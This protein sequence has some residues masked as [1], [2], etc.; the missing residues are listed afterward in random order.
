MTKTTE[1]PENW[2]KALEEKID[3]MR[4][5][6]DKSLCLTPGPEYEQAR[7][8]ERR[9][10]KD[11]LDH[12]QSLFGSIEN[13]QLYLYADLRQR[14]LSKSLSADAINSVQNNGYQISK[15]SE[16]ET[17][18]DL[19]SFYELIYVEVREG[20]DYNTAYLHPDADRTN[21]PPQPPKFDFH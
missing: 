12:I 8:D 17:A 9:T 7:K 21:T 18:H 6:C 2:Q 16:L 5:A 10:A 3:A 13:Y 11:L 1:I 20:I 15:S 19:A 14:A 4:V